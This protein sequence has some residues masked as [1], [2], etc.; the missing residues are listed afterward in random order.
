MQVRQL[1]C[2]ASLVLGFAFAAPVEET[3]RGQ[4]EKKG[5]EWKDEGGP[6]VIWPAKRDQLEKDSDAV[7]LWKKDQLEKKGDEWKDEGGPSV[8]WPAKRDQLEKDSDAVWL[9]KKGKL[10]KDNDDVWLW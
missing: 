7:W 10:Q 9:W 3:K 6:S 5:D 8:I 4:L 1:A 2:V